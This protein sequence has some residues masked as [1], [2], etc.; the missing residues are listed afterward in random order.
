MYKNVNIVNEIKQKGEINMLKKI[1]KKIIAS[2]VLGVTLIVPISA[3]ASTGTIEN[4]SNVTNTY[5]EDQSFMN[6]YNR[7]IDNGK[8]VFNI[9]VKSGYLNAININVYDSLGNLSNSYN[10]GSL[11]NT[12]KVTDIRYNDNGY[13]YFTVTMDYTYPGAPKA[14]W[15][16]AGVRLFYNGY[17]NGNHIM[18]TN[19]SN[20]STVEGVGY[21]L[22]R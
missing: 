2:A 4:S 7:Y 9:R 16:G 3:S 13:D 8:F 5:V 10:F 21:F 18:A 1:V 19:T 22:Y 20:G 15:Y 11:Q 17:Y 12:Y 6:C 14:Y